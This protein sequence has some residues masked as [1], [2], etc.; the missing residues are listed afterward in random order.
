MIHELFYLFG[1]G[2]G[3]EAEEEVIVVLRM[4]YL[5]MRPKVVQ[6]HLSLDSTQGTNK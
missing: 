1:M 6:P 2:R 4:L 5:V 3:K